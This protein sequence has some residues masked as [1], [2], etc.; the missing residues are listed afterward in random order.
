MKTTLTI[1]SFTVLLILSGCGG[2]KSDKAMNESDKS[3]MKMDSTATTDKMSDDMKGMK[4]MNRGGLKVYQYTESP[5]F[6]D[7]SLS[8]ANP[9]NGAEVSAGKVAVEYDVQNYKLGAQTEDA[10]D[11]GLA[12]SGKGQHIHAILNNQPY[13]AYY[14][15]RFEKELEPGNYVL[16]SFLSRSYHESLKNESAMD[17]IQFKVGDTDE[18]SV[19]LNAP[20][21]FYSRPK[22]TYK[23]DDMKK[24]L[25]DF[26]LV[27]CDLSEDGYKVRATINGIEFMLTDWTAY[28]VEGL[29]P[30]EVTVNLAL[31]DAEGNLV[32]SPYNPS[33]RTV[34]L[35]K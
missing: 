24:L 2:G 7:A 3:D 23:G 16:L 32:E 17:L 27:N 30:G 5:T 4:V 10:T 35:E 29:D 21:L 33:E 13:M 12:N 28:L 1:L 6:D 26:Y 18:E 8:I 20:Q 34:I 22:G 9:K 25:L 19:D 31:L 14:E 15:P 11:N